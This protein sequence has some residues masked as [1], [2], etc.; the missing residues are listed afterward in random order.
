MAGPRRTLV[1]SAL[2]G[3]L[4]C[5]LWFVPSANASLEE[6]PP[7]TE[8]VTSSASGSTAG[9]DASDVSDASGPAATGPR[10]AETGT[11]DSTPYVA[12]GVAFLAAGS[13]LLAHAARRART[14]L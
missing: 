9:T 13:G 8:R 4:L 5:G 11:F 6:E 2:A 10:L 3:G 7:R 12:G 14:A 1:T